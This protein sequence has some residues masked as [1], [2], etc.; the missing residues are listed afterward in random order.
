[1]KR[2]ELRDLTLLSPGSRIVVSF[3][4]EPDRFS[5]II[6]GWPCWGLHV[7]VSIGGESRLLLVDWRS[8]A[9]L[10]DVT[11]ESD[12]LR[13][14]VN[15]ERIIDAPSDK[16]A[17]TLVESARG[18]ALM[19]CRRGNIV[20]NHGPSLLFS[21]TGE[22][23]DMPPVDCC[24]Q[25][26]MSQLGVVLLSHPVRLHSSVRRLYL[27]EFFPRQVSCAQGDCS[28]DRF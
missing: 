10:Y 12:Y 2:S 1:M 5:E 15:L 22:Q 6:T 17:W 20:D 23:L 8:V 25:S 16:D 13:N 11:G 24:H 19:E 27:C 18:E 7:L 4:G 28:R 3:H 9:G 26:C 21:W 14:V